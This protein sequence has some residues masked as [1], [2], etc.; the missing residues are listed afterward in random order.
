MNAPAPQVRFFP[1]RYEW[2]LLP[3][4][5]GFRAWPGTQGVTLTEDRFTARY[6]PVRVD[7]PLSQIRNAE[8]IGP[9][10]PWKVGGLRLSLADGGLTFGTNTDIGV[11]VQFHP[12]YRRRIGFRD[13]PGLTVTVDRADELLAALH[14]LIFSRG[15]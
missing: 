6:G 7:A 12:P 13:H 10:Q 11:C 14:E 8:I 1:Y 2:A 9:F 4:W 15:D 3:F 5:L